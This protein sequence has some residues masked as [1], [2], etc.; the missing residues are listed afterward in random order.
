M[1]TKLGI[2]SI[3]AGFFVGV[4]SIISKFMQADNIW[5]GLTLSTLTG[6]TTDT[7]VNVSSVEAIHDALYALFYQLHLGGVLVGLG[8]IF[9]VISLFLKEH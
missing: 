8:V 5:V 4:F 9:L 3:L 7:I 1:F 2:L 6:D